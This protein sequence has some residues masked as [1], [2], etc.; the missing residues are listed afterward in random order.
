MTGAVKAACAAGL[1]TVLG[2]CSHAGWTRHTD[3]RLV[4]VTHNTIGELRVE[5]VNGSVRISEGEAGFAR[6]E[7]IL[8]GP[9]VDRLIDSAIIAERR[10]D[11]MF[12][13][14]EWAGGARK[15]G[16]GCD[17]I[18][19]I[20]GATAV[21]VRTSNDE[22]IVDHVG[23]SV[24]IA[25]SNDEVEVRGVP[26]AVRVATSNDNVFVQ[27]AEGAVDVSTSNDEIFIELGPYAT[28]PVSAATSNDSI[29]LRVGPMFGGE[30]K[31]STSNGRV[32]VYG[33]GVTVNDSGKRTRAT[34][35]FDQ[36]GERSTLSTSNSDITI[37]VEG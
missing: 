33:D 4:T 5:S 12:I 23:E 7:A 26:G 13:G 16:E 21:V 14:V 28:G 17:F 36:G 37:H 8:R 20:P 2:G 30:L 3:E 1:I 10:G 15:N 27:G 19:T 31:A 34:L 9:D 25:T 32:R 24:D 11:G 18:I 35:R 22:V 29:E 6:I